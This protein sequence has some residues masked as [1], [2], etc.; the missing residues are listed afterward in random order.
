MSTRC[1]P[2]IPCIPR[3]L[4]SDNTGYTGH[5]MYPCTAINGGMSK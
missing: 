2:C 3:A 5:H 1:T 4:T